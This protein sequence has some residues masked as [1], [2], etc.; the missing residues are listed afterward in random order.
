[1]SFCVSFT[2]HF[3]AVFLLVIIVVKR[4]VTL[5]H[6]FVVVYHFIVFL[7]YIFRVILHIFLVDT[8]LFELH[9]GGES[10]GGLTLWDLG[11]VSSISVY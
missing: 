11:P 1:M 2:F 6:V 8:S 9:F 4:C 10:H 3:M 7:I 5:Q